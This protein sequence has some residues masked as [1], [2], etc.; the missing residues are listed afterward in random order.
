MANDIKIK[1]ILFF[2]LT[3]IGDVILTL[4]SLDY[5]K[6]KFKD[7]SF[8]VLSGPNASVLFS[9]DARVSENITYDKHAPFRQK[10]ALF[11]R[12]KREN[13]DVII[14]LRDTAFRW[15]TGAKYKN[16]YIINVPKRIRHLK[17][18]HLYKTLAA[19]KET[20]RIF[21]IKIPPQSINLEEKIM[22]SA[23]DL[24]AKY[25]L[26]FDSE[27]IIVAPGARS[28]TKRW[29]TQGFIRVCHALMKQYSVV[30][31]G[32]KN[33]SAVTL[34][35]NKHIKFG[36]IDL[37]NQTS[38]L[39]A[40]AILKKAKLVICNDSAILQLA[41]YFNMPTLAIFGPTDE[42]KYGPYSDV[43]AV[44]RK[45]TI[46]TPCQKDE[47]KNDWLCMIEV[48]PAS[49]ID[50]ANSLING[51]IPSPQ[52][53]FRRILVARTDR[54]GDVLLSTPVIKNLRDRFPGTYIAAMIKES[55]V[56]LLRNNPY[57][58]EV[59][60]FD[61]KQKHKGL[62]GSI[63]FAREL[64]KRKFDLALILHPTNRVH[65]ILFFAGIKQR[66]GYDKKWGKLNTR[67]LKHDKQ[68]GQKHETE[69]ALDFLREL[70]IEVFDK[71][72]FMSVHKESGEWVDSLFAEHKLDN[73]SKIVTVHT[74]ASCP[75]KIWPKEYFDDLIE[76][77]IKGHKANIVYIGEMPDQGIEESEERINLTGKTNISQLASII[78][79]S[80]LFISNDSGP[81]HMAVALGVPV[82]S[83][84]GRKQPGLGP[85][86]WGPLGEN[87][88]TLHKDVGCQI[89]LAHDCKKEFACLKAIDPK[90]VYVHVDKFLTKTKVD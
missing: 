79:R 67:I 19:F 57:L 84:F 49:V 85:K 10:L 55:L 16:P 28:S 48:T 42:N 21:D 39:E 25:K 88:I 15:F 37:G 8:T 68:F 34:D 87:S 32:D 44:M 54:M 43:S 72:L 4:P 80:R 77:I 6:D 18:R 78:K 35:I 60:A 82:I 20:D 33:D 61:K 59:I 3:N 90:E 29:L 74:Q 53:E 73:N 40:I 41:S 47:C 86:R 26:S 31:I 75:S 30:L 89:C 76:K 1:K 38:L 52:P 70:G 46:C 51:R 65:L 11:N 12:L 5:L 23:G 50:S 9:G 62:I 58:D 45:H 83:I 17:L 71:S 69:Y 7:A 56:D 36:C 22:S 66:I 27:Y 81:V 14:D 63:R 13:F 64:K 2:T 24:L